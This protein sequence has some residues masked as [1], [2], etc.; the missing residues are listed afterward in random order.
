[1]DD[2]ALVP[3]NYT[4]NVLAGDEY[5]IPVALPS[6]E[7]HQEYLRGRLDE[8]GWVRMG[9]A[10]GA[11]AVSAV[12]ALPDLADRPLVVADPDREPFAHLSI[13]PRSCI[14]LESILN[15]AREVVPSHD[16]TLHAPKIGG[17]PLD[18]ARDLGFA[19]YWAIG[20]NMTPTQRRK[21]M[22]AA[23]WPASVTDWLVAPSGMGGSA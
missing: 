16:P 11:G 4:G 8:R 7:D 14:S 13:H 5:C 6:S 10:A 3:V 12:L 15:A 18:Q 1:M 22:I 21:A 23:G 19:I 9:P 2:P 17:S 20:A